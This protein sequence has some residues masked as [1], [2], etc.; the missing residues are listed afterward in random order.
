MSIFH[1]LS[2][3]TGPAGP[4][5]H[6]RVFQKSRASIIIII[7]RLLRTPH[8]SRYTN[9]CGTYLSVHLE[10]LLCLFGSAHPHDAVGRVSTRSGCLVL[11]P[12]P[13]G[14]YSHLRLYQQKSR[15]FTIVIID[16]TITTNSTIA[17][18]QM[19]HLSYCP[20]RTVAMFGSAHPHHT[21][22]APPERSFMYSN[23]RNKELE[24]SE[25]GTYSNESHIG[26]KR[27]NS[28]LSYVTSM[29]P[30][31]KDRIF[32]ESSLEHTSPCSTPGPHENSQEKLQQQRKMVL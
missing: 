24:T 28:S 23:S 20:P 15:A 14:P 25:G 9:K 10:L 3:L 8:D 22:T 19:W 27:A 6:L 1:K 7:A 4:F 31:R 2:P 18:T 21:S 29:P 26:G 12:P 13:V 30:R 16:S 5:C 17:D 32:N 11:N